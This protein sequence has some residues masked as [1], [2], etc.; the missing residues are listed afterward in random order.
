MQYAEVVVDT[1]TELSRD[2]F[3]YSIPPALLSGIGPGIAVMVSFRKRRTAGIILELS[4]SLPHTL[5]KERVLPLE[6]ILSDRPILSETQVALARW[7]SDYYLSPL[8]K[9]IFS[10]IP[11]LPRKL[12]SSAVTKKESRTR[13]PPK[14][15]SIDGRE[16]ERWDAYRRLIKKSIARRQ[17]VLVL[18]PSREVAE[19]FAASASLAYTPFFAEGTPRERWQAWKAVADGKSLLVVGTRGAV[20]SP[21]PRLG[22]IIVDQESSDLYKEERSPRYDARTVAKERAGLE[23]SAVVFGDLYPSTRIRAEKPLQRIHLGKPEQVET[24][25]VDVRGTPS[26]VAPTTLRLLENANKTIV[27]V[28]RKGRGTSFVCR[29][30]GTAIRCPRCNLSLTVYPENLRC[31]HCGYRQET[32]SNCPTCR[33]VNF[34]AAGLGVEKVVAEIEKLCPGKTVGPLDELHPEL[35]ERWN[36]AVAT[37]KVLFCDVHADTVVVLGIET[38]FNLPEFDALE[39]TFHI[40]QE[41]KARAAKTFAVQTVMPDHR[42]FARLS[43]PDRFIGEE[44]VERKRWA[45]PPTTQYVRILFTDKDSHTADRRLGE[46][47]DRLRKTIPSLILQGPAPAFIERERGLFRWHLIAVLPRNGLTLKRR[48]RALIPTDVTVDVDPVTIL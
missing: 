13:R 19:R 43:D 2:T 48:L 42:I 16:Q 28:P 17:R 11:P 21:L 30:C 46:L 47:A 26:L 23:G 44:L 12:F 20:F 36:I 29:D 18:F 8:S 10:M 31:H 37:Q 3:T 33:G 39:K 34:R 32:P 38:M 9:A 25:I 27:F 24:S 45:L 1:K 4:R 15:Y 22:L 41:L 6:R 7:V 40:L 14:I 35:P 5:A